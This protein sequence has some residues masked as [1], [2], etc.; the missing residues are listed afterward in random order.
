MAIPKFILILFLLLAGQARADEWTTTD[1]AWQVTYLA[2]LE[3]DREQTQCI[4]SHC[5]GGNFKEGDA[6]R[7]I[8]EYPSKSEINRYF[9]LAGLLHTGIA[10]LL[11]SKSDK[12]WLP[13]RSTFQ[14]L[15]IGAEIAVVA[16]NYRIGVGF[17]F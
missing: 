15:F 2:L 1:I 13:S 5:D 3:I 16:R 9:L 17:E 8:G 10:N 14:H 4:R 6:A 12:W 11:P 7:F